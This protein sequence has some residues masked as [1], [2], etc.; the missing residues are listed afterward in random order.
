MTVLT[1]KYV[2]FPKFGTMLEALN[3]IIQKRTNTKRNPLGQSIEVGSALTS[4]HL[5]SLADVR[6]HRHRKYVHH[7]RVTREGLNVRLNMMYFKP[8]KNDGKRHYINLGSAFMHTIVI[9]HSSAGGV[10]RV[11]F[12]VA[13]AQPD[14]GKI[15]MTQTLEGNMARQFVATLSRGWIRTLLP[16]SE[17]AMIEGHAYNTVA[18]PDMMG[19]RE[20]TQIM[21]ERAATMHQSMMGNYENPTDARTLDQAVLHVYE[22]GGTPLEAASLFDIDI[23]DVVVRKKFYDQI[24]N[25]LGRPASKLVADHLFQSEQDEA[26]AK[27]IDFQRTPDTAMTAMA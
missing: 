27:Q 11:H 24:S 9:E 13:E 2:P 25:A 26:M 12:G 1:N 14:V 10:V 19:L 8:A 5:N 22:K 23:L 21:V 16:A 3:E 6:R 20:S 15:V 4:C 17:I 7:I 18:M